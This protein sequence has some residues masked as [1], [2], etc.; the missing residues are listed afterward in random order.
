MYCQ[1]GSFRGC[2]TVLSVNDVGQSYP[3]FATG[4]F[5]RAQ[6]ERTAAVVL[7]MVSQILSGNIGCATLVWAL[8]RKPRA[9]VLVVLQGNQ[10]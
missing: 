1:K 2:N 7:H 10:G 6:N 5:E 4:V 3:V 9:V 8:D